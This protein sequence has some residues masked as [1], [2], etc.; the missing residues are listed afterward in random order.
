MLFAKN[1][2]SFFFFQK[3]ILILFFTSLAMLST[4]LAKF[5]DLFFCFG[6][7]LLEL[8]VRFFHSLFKESL[9]CL[10]PF[11]ARIKKKGWKDVQKG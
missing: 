8:L 6:K 3:G 2:T 4:L 7:C 1:A 10:F 5:L 9:M 11:S